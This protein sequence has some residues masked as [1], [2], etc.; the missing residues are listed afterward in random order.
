MLM[1]RHLLCNVICSGV[2]DV[3]QECT[4]L[5][6]RSKGLEGT[7]SPHKYARNKIIPLSYQFL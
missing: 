7:I 4:V 2:G 5:K 1:T 6:E 3:H